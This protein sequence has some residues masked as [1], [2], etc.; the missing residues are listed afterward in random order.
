MCLA[1]L[2][3]LLQL[4]SRTKTLPSSQALHHTTVIWP[5]SAV[6][7][8]AE[9]HPLG[10]NENRIYRPFFEVVVFLSPI[11][12]TTWSCH[13]WVNPPPSFT[14]P[15]HLLLSSPSSFYPAHPLLSPPSL[16]RTIMGVTL[17]QGQG[18][19]VLPANRKYGGSLF[20]AQRQ[21]YVFLWKIQPDNGRIKRAGSL[22][23]LLLLWW[24]YLHLSGW[25]FHRFCCYFVRAHDSKVAFLFCL[26]R[27]PKL[28]TC[29]VM[30][31]HALE[32]VVVIWLGDTICFHKKLIDSDII[33]EL[34]KI[35]SKFKG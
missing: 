8:A 13:M 19:H 34:V 1:L 32:E 33:W 31:S 6:I 30:T 5:V 16:D 18:L 24:M 26:D 17:Y 29:C 21:P 4:V 10:F 20:A 25:T 27:Y 7:D 15:P 3:F 12:R 9:T 22:L 28:H 2:H 23:E 11:N 35:D 14:L